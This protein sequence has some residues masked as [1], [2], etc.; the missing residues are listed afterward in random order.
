MLREAR[1]QTH[2][3]IIEGTFIRNTLQKHAHE[4]DTDIAQTMKKSGFRSYFWNNR[5][6]AVNDNKLTYT[7]LPQHRFV[8]MRRRNTKDGSKRKKAHPIHNRIHYGHLNNLVRELMYGFTK[9][10]QNEIFKN[11]PDKIYL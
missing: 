4:V 3:Q 8:D 11:I 7:H 10:V 9:E 1:N 5:S 2:Q 6:F